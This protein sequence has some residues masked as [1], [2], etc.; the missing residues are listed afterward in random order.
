MVCVVGVCET[1][2]P[3]FLFVQEGEWCVWVMYVGSAVAE[4]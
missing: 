1:Y 2:Q 4:D 3:S